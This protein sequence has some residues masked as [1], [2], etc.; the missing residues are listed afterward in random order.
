MQNNFN[1]FITL[2]LDSWCCIHQY[3]HFSQD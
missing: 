1:C 3:C 2:W